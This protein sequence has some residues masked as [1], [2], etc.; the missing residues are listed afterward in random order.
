MP[1]LPVEVFITLLSPHG[2]I[3][4]YAHDNDAGMDLFASED[5]LIEPGQTKLVHTGIAI[6]LPDGYEAQIRPRSGLSLHSML[7]IPNSPGTIDAGYRDEICIIIHNASFHRENDSVT[8][9]PITLQEKGNHHG[10]YQICRGDRIA[11]MVIAQTTKAQMTV[12]ESLRGIGEDRSGGF[13]ST[14]VTV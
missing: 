8:P 11:Q 5:V 3:P 10:T 6:A 9:V 4:R 13:G 2:V 1:G 12:V 14:G 7:R